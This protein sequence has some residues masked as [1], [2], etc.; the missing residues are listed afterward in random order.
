MSSMLPPGVPFEGVSFTDP[1]D[2]ATAPKMDAG[3][4]ISIII[5]AGFFIL[6]II[7]SF[8]DFYN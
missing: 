2:K 8:L 7:G 3:T 1:D 6:G 5:I 4:V